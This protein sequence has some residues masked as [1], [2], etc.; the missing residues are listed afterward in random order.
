MAGATSTNGPVQY[1]FLPPGSPLTVPIPTANFG[2]PSSTITGVA[3][4]WTLVLLDPL[5]GCQS[6]APVIISTNTVTPSVS[7]SLPTQTLSC[8]N[9]TILATGSSTTANTQISWQT[10]GGP[11][12]V[13]SSS[14]SVGPPTGPNTNTV[15][16]NNYATYTVVATNTLNACKN[17]LTVQIYQD[18][19]STS[20]TASFSHTVGATGLVNFNNTTVGTSTNIICTWNFGDGFTITGNSPSHT[21]INSG[22]YNVKLS[23]NE[24]GNTYCVNSVTQSVNVTSAPCFANS[25]FTAVPTGT[26]QYW[27]IIPSYPWNVSNATWNWGDATS[28]SGIYSSHTYSAA[29][30]YTICLTVTVSCGATSSTCNYYY[31]NKTNSNMALLNVNVISPPLEAVGIEQKQLQ[32]SNIIIYPNPNNGEFNLDLSAINAKNI[33]ISIYDIVGQLVYNQSADA[34]N[35]KISMSQLQ[36]GTY[37]LKINADNKTVTQKIIIN[38]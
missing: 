25:N 7:F 20:T 2:A 10:P 35:N 12:N 36:N 18:F 28:S 31:I 32:T 24:A 5:S 22:A 30:L 3:G 29:A 23:I 14:V 13:Y 26:A 37:F 34:I 6:A 33:N 38:K 21:F 17:T 27:N 19:N 9:P 8:T 4:T 11:F 15:A 16:L 1:F